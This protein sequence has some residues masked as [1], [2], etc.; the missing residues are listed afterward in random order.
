MSDLE[1]LYSSDAQG[2]KD[3]EDHSWSQ[4]WYNSEQARLFHPASNKKMVKIDQK[5][6]TLGIGMF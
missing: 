5:E 6:G 2:I 1:A 4:P 3:H